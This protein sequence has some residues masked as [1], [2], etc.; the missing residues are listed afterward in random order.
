[1]TLKDAKPCPFCGAEAKSW[2]WNG[3]TVI[4]CSEYHPSRHQVSIERKT[5]E[6]CLEAWNE[7]RPYE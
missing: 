4:Q 5:L 3:G 1:M 2:Q 7:R 6:E